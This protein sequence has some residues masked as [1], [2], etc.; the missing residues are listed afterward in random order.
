MG[1]GAHH[2]LNVPLR[3]GLRT[4]PFLRVFETV[5]REIAARFVPQV[6]VLQCGADGA[7]GNLAPG[8]DG[9]AARA[10]GWNLDAAAYAGV[11][12]TARTLQVPLLLLGGGGYDNPTTARCW[13]AATAAAVGARVPAADE[14]VPE[15]ALWAEYAHSRG[16][17]AGARPDEND[18][19]FLQTVLFEATTRV[20]ECP[21]MG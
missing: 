14:D 17:K 5:T 16:G 11:V 21:Q 2:A 19:A 10:G 9:L 18:D 7:D 8:A 4:A 12:E 6:V 15:H 1:K 13:A 20:R 3:R